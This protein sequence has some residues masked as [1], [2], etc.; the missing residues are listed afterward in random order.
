MIAAASALLLSLAQAAPPVAAADIEVRDAQFFAIDARTDPPG[1]APSA[2]IVH[3]PETSCF[4]WALD[5]VPRSG[6]ARI[7]EELRLPAP[8][9]SW[10]VESTVRVHDD[11]AGAT[12]E[13]SDDLS[14]GLVTGEWCITEGDPVGPHHI[15][16][17]SGDRLLRRFE[18][19]V[20]EPPRAI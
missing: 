20:I 2:T 10:P 9:P 14:D 18:F 12:N 16:V 5:V 13:F 7:R 3:R 17:F 19:T 8:S 6:E 1:I 15:E 11:R 4:G